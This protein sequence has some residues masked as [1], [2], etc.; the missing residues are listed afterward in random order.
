M[1]KYKIVV[2]NTTVGKERDIEEAV[3]SRGGFDDFELVR[4]D[5]SDDEAFLREAEDA[6]GLC[7]WAY[8]DKLKYERLAKCKIVVSPGIGVD[9]FNLKDA[10]DCGVCIV[11]VPDYC[12]EDVAVHTAALILDCVRRLTCLDRDVRKG[13]WRVLACGKMYR[14]NGRTYGLMSFGNIPRRVAELMKPFGVRMIA[15]DPF[16]PDEVFNKVGVERAETVKQLFTESDY[17]S[18]HTPHTADTHHMIGKEELGFMRDGSIIVV[19]G[20]GGVADEGALK[21]ALLNG[22]IGCAGIDVIEN[23]IE[24]TSVLFGLDNVVIT[25]HSAYYTEESRNDLRRKT[26]EAIVYTVREK[27]APKNL[28]NKDVLG[29]ARFE[30]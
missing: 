8:L 4:V 22:K 20:R 17:I 21:D 15:Y 28:I 9:R 24:N 14:M 10:T 1:S 5:G 18:I 29:R 16:V 2:Y 3:L 7:V 11:N 13:G 19:T 25:P 6:D 12:I 27:K 26:I 30:K 23:E